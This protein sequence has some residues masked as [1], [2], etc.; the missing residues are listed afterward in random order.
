ML[1]LA[2]GGGAADESGESPAAWAARAAEIASRLTQRL[3]PDQPLLFQLADCWERAGDRPRLEATLARLAICLNRLN[4]YQDALP[5]VRRVV[6]F[7]LAVYVG[8]P[9][10]QSQLLIALYGVLVA[11][12]NPGEAVD[13][14]E[15]AVPAVQD[16]PEKA[17][18]LQ[19][20]LAMLR[21][22]YLPQLDL[23]RAQAHLERAIALTAAG[24]AAEDERR[25]QQAFFRNGLA[26]VH[27]RRGDT[28]A[29][30]RLCEENL[31]AL[32]AE[33]AAGEQ[34]L[35]CSILYQNLALVQVARG[36]YRE[37]YR[38]YSKAIEIDPAYPEY[39]NDR[40]S[41][42]LKNGRPE[43][44]LADYLRAVEIGPPFAEAYANLGQAYRAL[45]RLPEAAAAYAHA[46]ELEPA[47]QL[48]RIGRAQTRRLAGDDEGALEDYDHLLA[49]N[50]PEPLLW[51]NRGA[52]RYGRQNFTA[53]LADFGR[54]LE[55]A[56]ELPALHRNRALVL[57]ALG[58]RA[59]AE[60]ARARA[61]LLESAATAPA[62]T[63]PPVVM[64][65]AEFHAGPPQL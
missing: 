33:F 20:M 55:L 50:P 13:L 22:R 5:I 38:A 18:A 31:A 59:E 45:G 24:G 21:A 65:S 28:A 3:G 23:A 10:R 44:A 12:G 58:R 16:G 63:P 36:G 42:A 57:E 56:P 37:A 9:D 46:L 32:D 49:G 47:L 2:A 27:Y 17:A 26:L 6:P 41:L 30:L 35:F 60:E 4:Y 1:P 15:R 39:Y 48:A 62:A 54:A 40:G 53:A 52:I 25:F 8:E 29:A 34:L 11:T 19:Y 51:A 14:L 43:L 7:A 61:G 64:D